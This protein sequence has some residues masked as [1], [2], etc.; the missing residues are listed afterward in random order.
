MN[1]FG[2]PSGNRFNADPGKTTPKPPKSLKK[3][4]N[5]FNKRASDLKPPTNYNPFAKILSDKENN[6]Q[7]YQ[8]QPISYS[9]TAAVRPAI[10]E[11]LQ[12]VV[13]AEHN[14][15]EK[16]NKQLIAE[17]QDYFLHSQ[18]CYNSANSPVGQSDQE[19]REYEIQHLVIK[20]LAQALLKD[21]PVNDSFKDLYNK[22]HMH[23]I[24]LYFEKGDR[25]IPAH[26]IVLATSEWLRERIERHNLRRSN[27]GI[28]TLDFPK[29]YD[30]DIF[31]MVLKIM[32]TN[33]LKDV[34]YNVQETRAMYRLACK[35]K[36]NFVQRYLIVYRLIPKLNMD[37]CLYILNEAYTKL[38]I[39]EIDESVKTLYELSKLY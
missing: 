27:T 25:I 23:D 2:L 26:R 21:I 34:E 37:H 3:R 38:S 16:S 15:S 22:N 10:P 7:N 12:K 13:P 33:D 8:N 19:V 28:Y 14:M 36:L 20:P 31:A 24:H 18:I 35:L 29:E 39:D 5:P 9:F 6:P 1:P 32:Y 4:D 30:P 11:I 17:V